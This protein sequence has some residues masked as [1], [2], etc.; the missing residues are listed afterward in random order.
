MTKRRYKVLHDFAH[1]DRSQGICRASAEV[2]LTTRQ[3]RYLLLSGHLAEAPEPAE[4]TSQA[5]AATEE[6]A[7]QP[8][9]TSAARKRK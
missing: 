8:A 7:E 1:P 3:A 4:T 6:S 2:Q 5:T 9:D